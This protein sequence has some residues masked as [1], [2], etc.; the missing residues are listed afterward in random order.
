MASNI[1]NSN[2]SNSKDENKD[3]N[4][5][6]NN[7][8]YNQQQQQTSLNAMASSGDSMSMT[9]SFSHSHL[10]TDTTYSH[11]LLTGGIS[12]TSSP[13]PYQLQENDTSSRQV[14]FPIAENN[15]NKSSP[16]Q[17]ELSQTVYKPPTEPPPSVPPYLSP[18]LTNYEPPKYT[19]SADQF[20]SKN[21]SDIIL[22]AGI[23]NYNSNIAEEIKASLQSDQSIRKAFVR[24]VYL[25]LTFQLL[26]TITL[27]VFFMYCEPVKR[28]VAEYGYSLYHG[29]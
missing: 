18:P 9:S 6:N 10:E 29:L 2:F 17:Q 8:Y 4:S 26:L 25:L 1:G 12:R 19:P 15:I 27:T 24:K 5:V 23:S 11:D 28:F 20:R 21:N 14:Q 13:A 22:E 7:N 16:Q 3:N